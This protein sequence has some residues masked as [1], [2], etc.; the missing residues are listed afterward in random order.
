MFNK[1]KI[2]IHELHQNIKSIYNAIADIK[3]KMKSLEDKDLK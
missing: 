3:S 2:T 1:T